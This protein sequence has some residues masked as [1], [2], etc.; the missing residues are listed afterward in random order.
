M[1]SKKNASS[2]VYF[3]QKKRSLKKEMSSPQSPCYSKLNLTEY[4]T[5]ALYQTL[6]IFAKDFLCILWPFLIYN[7]QFRATSPPRPNT[8]WSFWKN[9]I[10]FQ[11]FTIDFQFITILYLFHYLRFVK[12]L[13]KMVHLLCTF[14]WY[15]KYIIHIFY[16]LSS[17]AWISRNL[18]KK[19][20][21]HFIEK[22]Q[23]KKE[24]EKTLKSKCL[25]RTYE[26]QVILLEL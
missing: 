21:Q 16:I 22:I 6:F 4:D 19:H 23:S 12:K 26:K 15:F 10:Y 1:I 8:F 13:L 18:K 2:I 7:R 3:R 11:S 5:N 20:Y 14:F 24:V 17:F 25:T 9:Y